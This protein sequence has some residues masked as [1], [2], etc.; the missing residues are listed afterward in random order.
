MRRSF[1]DFLH[2]LTDKKVAVLGAGVSNRPLIRLL[3]ESGINLTIFDRQTKENLAPFLTELAAD[4]YKPEI[5]LGTDYLSALSGFDLIFKTP[6]VRI[7]LPELLA[8]RRRGCIITSEMEVF[9]NFCPAEVFAISGSDGKT[10]TSSLTAAILEAAGYHTYLGGNIGLPLLNQLSKMAAED[11]VVVELSSFQLMGM[12]AQIDNAALTNLSPNHLDV[13]KDYEEYREAKAQIF[14]HQGPC[15]RLVLNGECAEL[16]SWAMEAQGQVIWTAKRP[17]GD[18]ELYGIEADHLFYQAAPALEREKL[19]D[20]FELKLLGRHN[21]LNVLTA[22]ALTKEVVNRQQALAAVTAFTGVEHRIELIRTLDGVDYYNSSIDSSPSRTVQ[23]LAV[24]Q[25]KETP[26]L[27]IAGGKDKKLDYLELG[28][29]ILASSRKLYLY[30]AN[31]ALIE[32]GVQAAQ[33]EG[34]KAKYDL[35]IQHCDSYEEALNLAHQAGQKGEAVLLSPAGTSFD[36]FKN[37]EER[38][39]AFKAAVR[40]LA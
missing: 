3:L 7:D 27:L 34:E 39:K 35:E 37:F 14:R 18:Q 40:E 21:A 28:H 1:D 16:A 12:I 30:G 23:T 13:H 19:L 33:D 24:F 26:L 20:R 2:W 32:A 6:I 36:H 25:E 10:T 29:A 11:K 22:L 15:G 31:A 38:G 17:F 9:L 8:E 4:G 5:S